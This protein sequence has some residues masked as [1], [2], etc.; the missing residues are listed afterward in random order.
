MSGAEPS[1]AGDRAGAPQ[2]DGAGARGSDP[3]DAVGEGESGGEV[4]EAPTPTRPVAR[5]DD[6]AN[7]G[8][9]DG[10]AR[11]PASR[12]ERR[13]VSEELGTPPFVQE[14]LELVETTDKLRHLRT[15]RAWESSSKLELAE[16]SCLSK[17]KGSTFGPLLE[18]YPLY[19]A[20][21]DDLDC[22]ALAENLYFAFSSIHHK[23]DSWDMGRN[24][25]GFAA[26]RMF[27]VV[28]QDLCPGAPTISCRG[29]GCPPHLR[30][31]DPS[32]EV[33]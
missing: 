9:P 17:W 30:E 7:G 26:Y 13:C 4:V 8:P 29:M 23:P 3:V 14:F 11:H 16:R 27:D 31:G 32:A 1:S 18:L 25:Y 2:A 20:P 28:V 15:W 33:P 24:T 19:H 5:S 22:P 10:D 12:G 6:A 21:G